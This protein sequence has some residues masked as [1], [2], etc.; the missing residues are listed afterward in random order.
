MLK[1]S[2]PPRLLK[3]TVA[4]AGCSM[5]RGG[6]EGDATGLSSGSVCEECVS[7]KFY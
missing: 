5:T 6:I 3:D 1:P 7:V 4:I 2:P